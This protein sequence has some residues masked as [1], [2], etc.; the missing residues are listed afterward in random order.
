M[1]LLLWC[2]YYFAAIFVIHVCL[3]A[4]SQATDLSKIKIVR[5]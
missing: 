4:V 5:R 1:E 2:A 3:N